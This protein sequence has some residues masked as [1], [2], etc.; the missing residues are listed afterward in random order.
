MDSHFK[1]SYTINKRQI[2]TVA[3]GSKKIIADEKYRKNNLAFD[4][5]VQHFCNIC[6]GQTGGN[7]RRDAEQWKD[8]YRGG[9]MYYYFDRALHLRLERG[10]EGVEDRE[11]ELRTTGNEQY[12]QSKLTM[13][14]HT[15]QNITIIKNHF[16][17]Y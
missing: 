3:T 15:N 13:R 14:N 10:Q 12:A 17:Q 2:A 6:T 5:V 9:S 11:R 1:D 7:G 4:A 16:N 8:L